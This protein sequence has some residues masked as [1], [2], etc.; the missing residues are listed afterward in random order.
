MAAVI[1][2]EPTL[3]LFHA[4]QDGLDKSHV[5]KIVHFEQ[6][7]CRVNW[8]AFEGDSR[9]PNTGVIDCG[10]KIFHHDERILDKP[11]SGNIQLGSASLTK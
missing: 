1:D 2:D 7:L 9:Y 4:G 6:L 8:N 11:A 10:L 3:P 5:T